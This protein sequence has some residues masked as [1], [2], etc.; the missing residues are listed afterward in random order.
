MPVERLIA[1]Y[2]ERTKKIEYRKI[3]RTKRLV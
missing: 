1:F 2:N 3:K